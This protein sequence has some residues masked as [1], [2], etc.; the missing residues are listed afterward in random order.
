MM[1]RKPAFRKT[2]HGLS[3]RLAMQALTPALPIRV[4]SSRVTIIPPIQRERPDLWRTDARNRPNP[5]SA[6]GQSAARRQA[7]ETFTQIWNEV[8]GARP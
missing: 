6:Q 4:P 8:M 5:P 3:A 1:I 2:P 7:D